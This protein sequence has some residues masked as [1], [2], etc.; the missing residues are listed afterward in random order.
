MLPRILTFF[1]H[2]GI[3][4][5][6]GYNDYGSQGLYESQGRKPV[7]DSLV[8]LSIFA[9]VLVVIGW[10]GFREGWFAGEATLNGYV[11]DE[12]EQS[13]SMATIALLNNKGE[14]IYTAG[15]SP[16]GKFNFDGIKPGKYLLIVNTEFGRYPGGLN[17]YLKKSD[18]EEFKVVL[19][20]SWFTEQKTA[21]QKA[22]QK[23]SSGGG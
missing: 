14:Q 16:D 2:R 13:V 12:S 5:S 15:L 6:M 9:V 23:R 21:A 8:W 7:S 20:Q 3:S 11:V 18:V 1:C 22:A 10:Y 17:V 4:Y 19:P